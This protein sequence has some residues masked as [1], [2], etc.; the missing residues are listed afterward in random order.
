[1]TVRDP[2]VA[3][4][5]LVMGSAL[6]LAGTILLCHF[7]TLDSFNTI[8]ALQDQPRSKRT[9]PAGQAQL[10]LRDSLFHMVD[11][12]LVTLFLFLC[13]S[14]SGLSEYMWYATLLAIMN[15]FPVLATYYDQYDQ[16]KELHGDDTVNTVRAAIALS[17]LNYLT[18]AIVCNVRR[19]DRSDGY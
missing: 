19:S 8:Q 11:V 1:M 10:H 13:G 6:A 17:W 16:L 7:T 18:I 9:T 2:T 14:I 5:C 15:G 3:V 12:Q 4:V